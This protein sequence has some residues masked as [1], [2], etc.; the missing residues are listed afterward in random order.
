VFKFKKQN[1]SKGK[2]NLGLA[3]IQT[4]LFALSA[5]LL[6]IAGSSVYSVY[7]EEKTAKDN[8]KDI[9]ENFEQ[10][11]IKVEGTKLITNYNKPLNSN[12]IL[13]PTPTVSKSPVP[14]VPLKERYKP[15]AKI[16]IKKI[17]LRIPVL[18]EWSYEL[19]DISV[20]KFSGP[21]PNEPGNFVIIGHNYLIG[22][23]FGDLHL[24]VKG[25]VVNLT[26][27]S[28][29]KKTYEVYETLTIKP[30]EVEK[31][32]TNEV[33]TVTLVTCSSKG[34]LRLVVKCKEII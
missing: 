20:C 3:T 10:K 23:H 5:I 28:G 6:L 25:D 12:E 27:L 22:A 15:I 30:D 32:E 11:L 33:C 2:N 19:L 26:D 8:A 29:K 24:L 31:L 1:Y 14:A 18:S 7:L 34:K 17:G 9:L 16:Y 4:W 13:Q 21:E